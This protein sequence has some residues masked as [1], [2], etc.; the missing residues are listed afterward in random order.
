MASAPA[1]VRRATDSAKSAAPKKSKLR[2]VYLR[3]ERDTDSSAKLVLV[4]KQNKA[5]VR[6]GLIF[7]SFERRGS[8]KQVQLFQ[9]D[10]KLFGFLDGL[11][12]P[13]SFFAHSSKTS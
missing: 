5:K 13:F 12:L 8:I 1:R 2:G 3:P 4:D 7:L 11:F 10:G 6:A 9:F